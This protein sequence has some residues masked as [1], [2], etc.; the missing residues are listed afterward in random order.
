MRRLL[1]SVAVAGLGFGSLAMVGGTALGHGVGGLAVGYGVLVV[2]A[3]LYL[4]IGLAIRDRM[5]PRRTAE[6]QS[7]A[8]PAIQRLA[9]HRLF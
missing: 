1:W 5:R 2:L 3:A 7:E 9:G 6:R 4:I 8:A